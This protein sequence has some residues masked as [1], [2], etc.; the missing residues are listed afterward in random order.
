MRPFALFS[1][2]AVLAAGSIAQPQVKWEDQVIYHIFPRSYRDSNGDRIGDFKGITQGLDAIQKLGCTM[3][4]LNPIFKSRVYHN[5]FADDFFTVDPTL[6]SMADFREMVKAIH[7]RH[8]KVILDMEPQFAAS[9]HPWLKSA[10]ANPKAPE[11]AYFWPGVASSTRRAPPWYNHVPAAI[12]HFNLDNPTVKAMVAKVFVFWADQGLDGFRIDHMMDDLD[13]RGINKD[14]LKSFWGPIE[15]DV[16][17]ERPGSFFVGEQ[18]DWKFGTDILRDTP[19]TAVF[20]FPLHFALLTFDKG[21]IEAA[22]KATKE[23]TPPGKVVVNFLENHD[24]IRFASAEPDPEKERLA[25]VLLF[26]LKGIPAIYY[27]QELGMKGKQGKWNSDGNDIPVRLAYRWGQTL[28]TPGTATWYAGTGPWATA[29][30]SA[31]HDGISYQEEDQSPDSLLN[32]YRRLVHLRLS[33][34]D[35]LDGSQE[36]IE[37]NNPNVLGFKRGHVRVLANLGAGTELVSVGGT[38]TFFNMLTGQVVG[39]LA[40]L[41]PYSA[42]IL[43][44]G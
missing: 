35:L 36:T 17:R 16:L 34:P 9:D 22:M 39:S 5:Y 31:D 27:G 20:G 30:Y 11:A 33:T 28:D 13:N 8:M 1:C 18:S 2:L 26:T 37:T 14:L 32:Y 29:I 42:V 19:T 43:N 6:G 23:N 41:T 44:S 7:H 25:A 15:K 4:M 3:I 12:A 10:M 21:K 38:G 24:M 40:T